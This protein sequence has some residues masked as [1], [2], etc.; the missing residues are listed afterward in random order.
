MQFKNLDP[1][2]IGQWAAHDTL[3]QALWHDLVMTALLKQMTIHKLM[4]RK[5]QKLIKTCYAR[6]QGA[7]SNE[8]NPIHSNPL[9]HTVLQVLCVQVVTGHPLPGG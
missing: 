3:P 5:I 8:P 4:K 7:G 9:S 2:A 6:F 1:Q